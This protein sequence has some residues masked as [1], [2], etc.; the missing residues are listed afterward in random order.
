LLS[1]LLIFL[2]SVALEIVQFLLPYRTFNIKD[3]T[4]NA[5]GVF[6]FDFIWIVYF[7]SLKPLK[8]D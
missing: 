7:Q 2:Y 8:K 5:Y 4:A 6:I 1:G 3:I